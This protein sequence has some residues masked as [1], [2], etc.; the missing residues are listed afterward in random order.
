MC[1]YIYIFL[2]VSFY[3][4]CTCIHIYMNK[5]THICH[6]CTPHS[7]I[8]LPNH[9]PTHTYTL[10]RTRTHTY[11]QVTDTQATYE[12]TNI[13]THTH[14]HARTYFT[15]TRIEPRNPYDA[16][17]VA[18]TN[19]VGSQVGHI[20]RDLAASLAPIMDDARPNA[21]RL[22]AVVL[23]PNLSSVSIKV[24]LASGTVPLHRVARLG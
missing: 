10:T 23:Q 7:P 18:V 9:P 1:V 16:N 2:I 20:T 17:A 12:H 6:V 19:H 3:D 21:P 5:Y 11:T 15:S 13:R 24:S 14:A 22:E 8:H 4:V